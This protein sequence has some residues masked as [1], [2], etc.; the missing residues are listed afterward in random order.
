MA[1]QKPDKQGQPD[2]GPG[3]NDLI[4]RSTRD[5]VW[6]EADY[7]EERVEN[8]QRDDTED[9]IPG[10]EDEITDMEAR[11]RRRDG[12]YRTGGDDQS[13]GIDTEMDSNAPKDQELPRSKRGGSRG[14][15]DWN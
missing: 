7:D 5:E 6:N 8:W 3:V 14:K 10:A 4:R 9:L 1:T 12:T 11:E 15:S 13:P 2:N